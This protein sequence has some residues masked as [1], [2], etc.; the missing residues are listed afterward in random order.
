MFALLICLVAARN[1]SGTTYYVSYSTGSDSNTPTEAQSK[2]TPWQHFRGMAS[3]TSNALSY[4]P[5]AGDTFILMGCDT[6]PNASFPI[7]WT[8]SGTSGSHITVGVDQ[9]WYNTSV[10]PSAWNRPIFNL[11]ATMINGSTCTASNHFV[12][13]F[14]GAQYADF[15]WIEVTGYYW[16]NDA[17]NSCYGRGGMISSSGSDYITVNNGYYHNWTHSASGSTDNDEMIYVGSSCAHCYFNQNVVD[18]ADGDGASCATS[19]STCSGFGDRGWN[20][21]R[22][23]C[24]NVSNCFLSPGLSTATTEIAYNNMF[25]VNMSYNGNHPNVI[26]TTGCVGG[27]CTYNI[28]DNYTHNIV[29]AE[30]LQVGN[31]NE[32]DNIW[33]NIIV[34][35]PSSVGSNGPHLPQS[36]SPIS[37]FFANNTIVGWVCFMWSGNGSYAWT[38]AL[39]IENNH[40]VPS[41]GSATVSGSPTAPTLNISN[42]VGQ[43]TATATSQ[44]YTDSETYV[45]SPTSGSG[46]T[47]GAGA[48]L[49]S[50]WPSG[51]STNDTTYACTEQ[52]INGVVESVCPARTSNTR[53][54]SGDWDA[55]AYQFGTGT[56]TSGAAPNPPTGL[57]AVVQ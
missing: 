53:P 17:Q 2:S 14:T 55:G 34:V 33:N 22:N 31:S 36:G 4:T 35:N 50:V 39:T 16:S 12:F 8:W 41:S 46:A 40:C 7:T 5:V 6:W 48:N 52:T 54:S 44:G 21:T 56:G 18:N 51:F 43:T 23:I 11:G 3:A 19:H 32:I 29:V 37:M 28:H 27:T 24:A 13:M 42:N 47:V 49:T 20:F 10:C 25:N 1:A 30:S 38:T 57:T 26:E 15:N 9:T 45:Y